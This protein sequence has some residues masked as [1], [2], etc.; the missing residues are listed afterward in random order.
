LR[1]SIDLLNQ[2]LFDDVNNGTYKVIFAKNPVAAK[3]AFD[4]FYARLAEYD[5]RLT[6]RRYLFG[7][8]ITDSDIRLFQTLSSFE[9][10]YRPA[11]A[12][13]F[14]EAET[15]QI[16]DFPHLWA[17][18]RDLFAQ[19]FASELEQ[20]FLGLVPGPSG[21]YLAG[22]GFLPPGYQLRPPAESLAAWQEPA[23]RESL[24]GSP[25]FSGPGGGGTTVHWTFNAL[26]T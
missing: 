14:G 22:K 21:D 15:K 12:K 6:T 17:Y 20:Y 7:D 3:S 11:L 1:Q 10:A 24:G 23:G 9:R 25:V 18:A 8:R 5:F 2:Q 26:T 13:I 16:W 4:V 19:G